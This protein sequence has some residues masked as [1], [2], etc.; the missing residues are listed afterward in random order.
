MSGLFFYG[1]QTAEHAYSLPWTLA[2]YT[3]TR[4]APR[5]GKGSAC[6]AGGCSRA[7]SHEAGMMPLRDVP[8][9]EGAVRTLS[10]VLAVTPVGGSIC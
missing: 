6:S 3:Q 4:A 7:G 2:V 5:C 1:P 8:H 9:D 10:G